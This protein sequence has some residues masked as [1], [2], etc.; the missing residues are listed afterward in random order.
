MFRYFKIKENIFVFFRLTSE[1]V[2]NGS[3]VKETIVPE[4]LS[5]GKWQH[6]IVSYVEELDGSTVV[7]KVGF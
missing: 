2:G 4:V 7:G 3:V 6:L 5:P 1:S